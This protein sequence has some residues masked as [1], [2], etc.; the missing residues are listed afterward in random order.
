MQLISF[1]PSAN[2]SSSAKPTAAISINE[3]GNYFFDKEPIVLDDL[4]TRLETALKA[5]PETL[6]VLNA[7]KNT[8]IQDVVHVFGI[9]KELG[10]QIILATEPNKE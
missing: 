3:K 5:D 9:A 10:I 1:L 8:A 6:V 4:R 2:S 7:E